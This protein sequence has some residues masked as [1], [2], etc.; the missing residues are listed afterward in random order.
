[1]AA[2][3]NLKISRV[4]VA[5]FCKKNNIE[6]QLGGNFIY[7]RYVRALGRLIIFKKDIVHE[8]VIAQ[9]LPNAYHLAGPK[10]LFSP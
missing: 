1:M 4:K 8:A 6:L 9:L 3:T 10:A 7:N 2:R 5:E